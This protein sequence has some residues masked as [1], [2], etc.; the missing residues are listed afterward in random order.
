MNEI[1]FM[2]D[3]LPV[4]T[5]MALIGFVTHWP[6]AGWLPGTDRARW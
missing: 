2:I 4:R 1:L 3:D 6:R 5:G